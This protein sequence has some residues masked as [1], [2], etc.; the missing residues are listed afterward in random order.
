VLQFAGGPLLSVYGPGMHQINVSVFKNFSTYHEQTLQFRAD[1]F[2]LL[3]TPW[4]AVPSYSNDGA[5][6]GQITSTRATGNFTP[7]ARFVQF[8]MTYKF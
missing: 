1:I 8:A 3:N 2:N 5:Y 7:D 4:F 6:G